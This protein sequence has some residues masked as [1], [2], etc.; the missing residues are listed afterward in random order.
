MNYVLKT[1]PDGSEMTVKLAVTVGAV[2]LTTTVA[3]AMTI[4]LW[5]QRDI[6][7]RKFNKK[8]K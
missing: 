2:A 3:T 8:F 1:Y 7:K 5:R 6:I 4:E